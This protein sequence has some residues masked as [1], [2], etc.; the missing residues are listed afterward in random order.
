MQSVHQLP[1]SGRSAWRADPHPARFVLAGPL[2]W[3]PE[4]ASF[5]AMRA[6]SWRSRSLA[7]PSWRIRRWSGCKPTRR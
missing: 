6:C 7:R 1:G 4:T 5:L 3:S 2:S